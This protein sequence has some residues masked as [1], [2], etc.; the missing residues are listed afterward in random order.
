MTARDDLL[1][2][3]SNNLRY[4]GHETAELLIDAYAREL[5]EAIR[6]NIPTNRPNWYK[7][8]MAK[9]ANLIDPEVT[10]G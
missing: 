10:D 1:E 5:A 2:A 3:L 9:G 8:G 6:E 4:V 7:Q